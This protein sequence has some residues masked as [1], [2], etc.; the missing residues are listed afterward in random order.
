MSALLESVLHLSSLTDVCDVRRGYFLVS[1]CCVGG[2]GERELLRPQQSDVSDGVL[3][4]HLR[5]VRR[6]PIRAAH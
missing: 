4:G 3:G 1:V 6:G 2:A 5:L